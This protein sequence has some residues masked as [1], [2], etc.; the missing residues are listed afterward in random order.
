[1]KRPILVTVIGV[2]GIIGG[3]A[4]T[5]FGALLIGLRNDEAFLADADIESGSVVAIAVACVVVGVLTVV[6]AIGLLKGSRVARAL[7]GVSELSRIGLGIYTIAALDAERRP[8]AVGNILTALVVL[9]FLFG[10]QKA[11]Q[12]FARR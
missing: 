4:Q 10:T 11:K 7:L 6:F 12:F 1:M 5:A 9:Y 2:V 3:I 8:A